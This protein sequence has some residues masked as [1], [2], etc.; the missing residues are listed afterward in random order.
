VIILFF[1]PETAIWWPCVGP[2]FLF[3]NL[4]EFGGRVSGRKAAY[5]HDL[6]ARFAAG[7]LSESSVAAM[8]EDALL[9]QLTKVK[10]IGEWTVHMFMI[11]SLHRP[12]V[13]PSGDLGVRKGVQ[14]L[15]KLKA[16]PKPEEM[17]G[18]CDRWRPYRSVGAWY[19]WRLLESKGAAAKKAKKGNASA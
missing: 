11:F 13:L 15:Y 1:A 19:M 14:E 16:L 2:N 18:L 17:A 8:D 12:D 6:A 9:A 10:G 7:D 3:Q 5:L 4:F